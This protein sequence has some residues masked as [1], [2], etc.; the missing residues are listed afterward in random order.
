MV[1]ALVFTRPGGHNLILEW[2]IFYPLPDSWRKP[3]K[4]TP[5]TPKSIEMTPPTPEIIIDDFDHHHHDDHHLDHPG[6][7]WVPPGGWDS[8]VIKTL[9]EAPAEKRFWNGQNVIKCSSFFFV[10]HQS[11]N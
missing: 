9:S 2:D 11:I 10:T 8:D 4:P 1:K 5:P 3:Q 6:E 7:I